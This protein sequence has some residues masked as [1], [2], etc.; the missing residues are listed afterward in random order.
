MLARHAVGKGVRHNVISSAMT[1]G[2]TSSQAPPSSTMP[3]PQTSNTSIN[4]SLSELESNYRNSLGRTTATE[5]S[6]NEE[7]FGGF[8]S[9]D[10]SL[11][12]LAMIPQ[13]DENHGDLGA[14]TFDFVD[15]PN[16]EIDPLTCLNSGDESNTCD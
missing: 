3:P 15:F 4:Q 14:E 2:P 16:I 10:S 13:V 9:R 5:E 6:S 7:F 11:V 12:D 8:L 1:T